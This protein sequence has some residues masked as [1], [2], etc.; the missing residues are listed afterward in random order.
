M[1]Q[2]KTVVTLDAVKGLAKSLKL[3]L[4][5][6]ENPRKHT[7]C[8]NIAA[9]AFGYRDWHS[10]E[11]HL[12]HR[13]EMLKNRAREV[14]TRVRLL[15]E[16]ALNDWIE[17][18]R[19]QAGRPGFNLKADTRL[20]G[21]SLVH[22]CTSLDG[23]DEKEELS[24]I[25]TLMA[26][27]SQAS[28]RSV[29]VVRMDSLSGITKEDGRTLSEFLGREVEP[30]RRNQLGFSPSPLN[31]LY[32][33]ISDPDWSAPDPTQELILVLN[34][35]SAVNKPYLRRLI[36]IGQKN[37]IRLLLHYGSD[38]YRNG[39]ETYVSGESR[40][41]GLLGRPVTNGELLGEPEAPKPRPASRIRVQRGEFSLS[42]RLNPEAGLRAPSVR[43]LLD[44][45][46][47]MAH[48]RTYRV[49]NGFDG[50]SNF[51]ADNPDIS[52]IRL[53][54]EC[55][56]GRTGAKVWSHAFGGPPPSGGV[57]GLMNAL[58][59]IRP[60]PGGADRP[61]LWVDTHLDQGADMVDALGE[62]SE[63]LRRSDV[64]LIL[65]LW[66]TDLKQAR[67]P[68]FFRA[69]D[70]WLVNAG[71]EISVCDPVFPGGY[72]AA[73]NETRTPLVLRRSDIEELT[74]ARDQVTA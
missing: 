2:V 40:W 72:G 48:A 43:D 66:H 3:E 24:A 59:V 26:L 61:V 51:F 54:E 37:G 20:F 5:G 71:S 9:R 42:F 57:R 10:C 25:A 53:D 11:G 62:L 36:R 46:H 29:R 13:E 17:K 18:S 31:Q 63:R 27:P 65:S 32:D 60:A 21:N 14:S 44:G 64:R 55:V 47:L 68:K 58:S 74:S 16:G 6:A 39:F 1:S 70:G 49:G 28:G 7:D 33:L 67:L 52:I 35:F 73:R 12:V 41:S 38:S 69:F 45:A 34:L 23:F 22:L 50:A 15:S 19:C 30:G 4:N 56:P 8:L